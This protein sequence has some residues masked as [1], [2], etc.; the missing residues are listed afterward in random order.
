MPKSKIS[1]KIK[2]GGTR[3]TKQQEQ[4]CR[5]YIAV[6]P[7]NG[8]SLLE[9]QLEALR[10]IADDI[11]K[12]QVLLQLAGA[13]Q[14]S[15]IDALKAYGLDF[16]EQQR[17]IAEQERILNEIQKELMEEMATE[18]AM[19]EAPEQGAL[20]DINTQAMQQ[21]QQ[22]L[23]MPYEQRRIMMR[24]LEQLNPTLYALTK[25]IMEKM[26]QTART[27]QGYQTLASLGMTGPITPP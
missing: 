13:Q 4:F 8:K 14:I 26:R 7:L 10:T 25:N 19:S 27:Q 9:Y 3:L 15:W 2:R 17:R 11:E 5:E 12:R 23:S 22:L 16:K 24:Q 21:A 18:M 20:P 1:K 6:V